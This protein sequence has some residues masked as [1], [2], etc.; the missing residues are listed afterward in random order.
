MSAGTGWTKNDLALYQRLSAAAERADKIE[1][2]FK[3]LGLEV[4]NHV[5]NVDVSHE[6]A[7]A[8]LDRLEGSER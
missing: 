1:A 8:I 5:G 2:R 6:Q 7:E 4:T 3:A